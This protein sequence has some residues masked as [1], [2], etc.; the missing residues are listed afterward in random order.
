LFC[1]NLTTGCEFFGPLK[2]VPR[3]LINRFFFISF[4]AV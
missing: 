1:I 4:A 3:P 2:Y